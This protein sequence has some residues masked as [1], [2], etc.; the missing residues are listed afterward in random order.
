MA[1]KDSGKCLYCGGKLQYYIPRKFAEVSKE[2]LSDFVVVKM[3][4]ECGRF[5]RDRMKDRS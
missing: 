4:G 5:F 3:C 2:P 1:K